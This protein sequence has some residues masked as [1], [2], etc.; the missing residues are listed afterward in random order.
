MPDSENKIAGLL[1]IYDVAQKV[2]FPLL[3]GVAGFLLTGHLDQETR[4]VRIE[5]SRY[6][7]QDARSDRER[8]DADRAA[9]RELLVRLDARTE[10][11]A[12]ALTRLEESR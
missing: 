6:T 7:V 3:L 11:M 9:I 2:G 5:S 10:A 12:E 8:A 1:A 4:L